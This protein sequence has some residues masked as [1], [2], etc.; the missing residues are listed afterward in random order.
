MKDK[1]SRS[2]KL[3]RHIDEQLVFLCEQRGVTVNSWL[4][5]IVGEAVYKSL[6]QH[7]M[8]EATLKSAKSSLESVFSSLPNLP[9][10][11]DLED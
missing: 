4:I 8:E 7:R 10:M 6:S 1:V 5:N 11:S 9:N 3:D 2:L